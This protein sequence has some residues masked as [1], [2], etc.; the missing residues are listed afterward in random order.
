MLQI[1]IA[2]STPSRL[3]GICGQISATGPFNKI[4][5]INDFCE[6]ILVLKRFKRFLVKV[7]AH[8]K[9]NNTTILGKNSQSSWLYLKFSDSH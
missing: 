5:A 1:G 2:N 7:G 8:I 6:F 9:I 4:T 3:N